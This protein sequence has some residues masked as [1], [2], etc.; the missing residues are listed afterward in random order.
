M[1]NK[2][3]TVQFFFSPP[4]NQLTTSL[5]SGSDLGTRRF[6]GTPGKDWTHGKKRGFLPLSQPP[7]IN[8]ACRLWCGIFPLVSLGCLRGRAPSQLLHTCSSAERG[9]LEKVLGFLATTKNGSVINILLI[10]N[11]NH[12]SYWVENWLHPSRNQDSV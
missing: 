4:D 5:G 11:P 10:L 9:R 12:S 6:H 2:Q 3:Y 8:W 1:Q 7:F